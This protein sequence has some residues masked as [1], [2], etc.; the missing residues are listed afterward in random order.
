[1]FESEIITKECL[2]V[3]NNQKLLYTH[4]IIKKMHIFIQIK[5]LVKMQFLVTH[6]HSSLGQ[7][8]T[9]KHSCL[10]LCSRTQ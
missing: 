9:R 5:S 7:W 3:N 2:L 6:T 1:M 8:N 10:S 4:P